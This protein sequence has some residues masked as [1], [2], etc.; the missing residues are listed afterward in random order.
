MACNTHDCDRGYCGV[1]HNINTK[2]KLKT[3]KK[4]KPSVRAHRAA[5]ILHYMR[6]KDGRPDDKTLYDIEFLPQTGDSGNI[7]KTM[8]FVALLT[9]SNSDV[10]F[11]TALS[12]VLL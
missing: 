6:E 10:T 9:C 12:K 8:M 5:V 3:C 4:K 7:N 1:E 2:L 11:I